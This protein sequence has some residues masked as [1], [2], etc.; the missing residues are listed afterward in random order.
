[1]R[2]F[3]ALLIVALLAA[4]AAADLIWDFEGTAS[5]DPDPVL[6][7][8]YDTTG[9]VTFRV[10]GNPG[11]NAFDVH[12]D[13]TPSNAVPYADVSDSTA[14]SAGNDWFVRSDHAYDG[15]ATAKVGDGRTGDLLTDPFLIDGNSS[16]SF[17]V[18]GGILGDGLG[19][20]LHDASNGAVLLS[21]GSSKK[22]RPFD[23][24]NW[25]SGDLAGAGVTGPT[26][27]YLRIGDGSTGG[28]GHTAVDNI[29]ATGATP[30]P[31]PTSLALL[32]LGLAGLALT[33]RRR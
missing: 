22:T 1:M 12:V 9:T 29:V 26:S 5:A 19:L 8:L 23:L 6:N 25:T 18:A 16:F 14:S 20:F 4:P 15:A 30:I 7:R 11:K 31:E 27:V 32:G 3:T 33:R 21:A 28:W 17:E 10:D 13:G 24:V 2:S